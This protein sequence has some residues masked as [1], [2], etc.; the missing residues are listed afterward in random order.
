MVLILHAVQAVATDSDPTITDWITAVATSLALLS[1]L[2]VLWT[3][4]SGRKKES[5]KWAMDTLK[6]WDGLTASKEIFHVFTP[7]DL[8]RMY[9]VA[10]RTGTVTLPTSGTV[11]S[12]EQFLREPDFWDGVAYLVKEKA[13]SLG[14]VVDLFGPVVKSRWDHWCPTILWLRDNKFGIGDRNA[15]DLFDGLVRKV[16]QRRPFTRSKRE[17]RQG[18]G[19]RWLTQYCEP[20]R[21]ASFVQA[22]LQEYDDNTIDDDQDAA[23]DT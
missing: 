8:R 1:L 16:E 19:G 23:P 20:D 13:I 15:Y 21:E 18:W 3:I 10:Y 12:A 2:G 9:Q 5:A 6:K 14:A 7:T 4:R 22:A 17:Q 11:I